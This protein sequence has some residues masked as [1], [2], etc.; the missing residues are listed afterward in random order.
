MFVQL[1]LNKRTNDLCVKFFP[2]QSTAIFKKRIF[3][4]IGGFDENQRY[5]EEGSYFMKICLNYNYFL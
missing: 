1:F 2:S 5:A 4:E 3:E